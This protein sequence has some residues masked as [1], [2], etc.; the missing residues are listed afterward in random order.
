MS[1][2]FALGL[3]FWS[4]SGPGGGSTG[5]LPLGSGVLPLGSGTLPLGLGGVS[6]GLGDGVVSLGAGTV[7]LGAG[8]VPLGLGGGVA[9]PGTVPLGLGG[10]FGLGELVDPAGTVSPGPGLG[11]GPPLGFV[12]PNGPGELAPPPPPSGF[13]SLAGSG[14]SLAQAPSKARAD[15]AVAKRR[16]FRNM[17]SRSGGPGGLTLPGGGCQPSKSAPR[18][19]P[20]FAPCTG[21]I[22]AFC[23]QSGVFRW[24]LCVRAPLCGAIVCGD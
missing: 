14:E 18:V 8:T 10:V 6:L 2:G 13:T 1:P 4:R 19:R 22:T 21:L 15:R 24:S 23:A 9:G 20:E 12:G 17:G 7:P 5:V 16:G 3:P 11:I